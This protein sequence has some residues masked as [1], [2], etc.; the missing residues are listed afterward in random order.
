M[1]VVLKLLKKQLKQGSK[2][3]E[4][5]CGKGDFVELVQADGSFKISGY[6]AAYEGKNPSIKKRYLNTKD[7]I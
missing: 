3:V 7:R 5:G 4:V 2:I 6:D 1:K